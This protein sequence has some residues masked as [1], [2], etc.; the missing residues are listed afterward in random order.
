M[1]GGGL[2]SSDAGSALGAAEALGAA[3]ALAEGAA[4]GPGLATGLAGGLG[5]CEPPPLIIAAVRVTASALGRPPPSSS[6]VLSHS[7]GEKEKAPTLAL[8]A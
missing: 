8:D 6:P 3:V 4:D 7:L 5:P 2:S 1:A